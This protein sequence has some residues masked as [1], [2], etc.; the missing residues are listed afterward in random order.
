LALLRD[1]PTELVKLDASF[2]KVAMDQERGR[3]LLQGIV[4]LAHGL[5]VQVVA[6][7]VESQEQCAILRQ[8][9][10]DLLQGFCFAPPL[11]AGDPRWQA[12]S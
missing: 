5:G 1:V 2:L 8:M 4:N 7:G 3:A 9:G 11:P 12:F 10:C 6:E